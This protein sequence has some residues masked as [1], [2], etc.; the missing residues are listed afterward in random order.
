VRGEGSCRVYTGADV[1]ARTPSIL[2][3]ST[4]VGYMAFRV[5][6][7]G[8]RLKVIVSLCFGHAACYLPSYLITLAD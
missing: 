7:G 1:A 5:L 6:D 2:I 4:R 3:G 8:D